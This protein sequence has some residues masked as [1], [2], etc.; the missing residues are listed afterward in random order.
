MNAYLHYSHLNL[1]ISKLITE[2][3]QQIA[4]INPLK[5]FIEYGIKV[6]EEQNINIFDM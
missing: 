5:N 1:I 3:L 6:Q 2:E 4:F